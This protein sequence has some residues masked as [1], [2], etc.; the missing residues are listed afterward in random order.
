MQSHARPGEGQPSGSQPTLA[1]FKSEDRVRLASSHESGPVPPGSGSWLSQLFGRSKP[2][3]RGRQSDT[4]P[5]LAFS[6]E[7][8][9]AHGR[10]SA[11]SASGGLVRQ[12]APAKPFGSRTSFL[13]A[14]ALALFG[15]LGALAVIRSDLVKIPIPPARDGRLTIE[16]QPSGAQVT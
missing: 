15:G 14:G 3:A 2:V 9:A 10:F 12:V 8:S 11:Q 7:T 6:S 5:L 13:V 16:T 1:D 4:N